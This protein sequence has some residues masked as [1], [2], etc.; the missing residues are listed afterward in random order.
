[1]LTFKYQMLEKNSFKHARIQGIIYS[2]TLPKES[3]KGK[4]LSRRDD[5]ANL[6]KRTHGECLIHIIIDVT[7]K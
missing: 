1:M 2:K 4:S 6:G 3:I 7:T 5:W